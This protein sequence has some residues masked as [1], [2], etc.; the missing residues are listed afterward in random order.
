MST[1]GIESTTRTVELGMGLEVS[2]KE[3][4]DT[5]AAAGYGVLVLHG[6]AGSAS[7]AGSAA[8]LAEHA[9]VITPTHPGFDGTPRVPWTDS[10]ADLADGY[11]GLLEQLGL[12]SVMVIGNSLGGWCCSTRSAS[13]PTTTRSSPTSA[14]SPADHRTGRKARHH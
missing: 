11:L 8:A 6:G 14:V 13:A 10:V 4:G 9:Y 5:A 7:V 2:I 12:T 1:P 3:Y